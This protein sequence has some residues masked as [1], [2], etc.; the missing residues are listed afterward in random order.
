MFGVGIASSFIHF[1]SANAYWLEPLAAAVAVVLFAW[2][3]AVVFGRHLWSF[4]GW[5]RSKFS[6]DQSVPTTRA[7][8]VLNPRR[9]L[10]NMG[11]RGDQ[12]AMQIMTSWYVTNASAVP[13]RILEAGLIKPNP[14]GRMCTA[15]VH[16]IQ[17]GTNWA[18]EGMELEIQPG[19]TE[20]VEANFFL[21]PP[22][23]KENRPLK[24]KMYVVDQFGRRHKAPKIKLQYRFPSAETY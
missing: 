15:L 1:L 22:T 17:R 10:W 14:R 7:A 3:I 20:T 13:M 8:F 12:P 19:Q 6:R 18:R 21:D 11:R 9:T 2:G 4:W 5:V 24:L 16:V 23:Q